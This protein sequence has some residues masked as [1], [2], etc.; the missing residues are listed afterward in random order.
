MFT[1]QAE[2][3]NESARKIDVFRTYVYNLKCFNFQTNISFNQH[4]L[5]MIDSIFLAKIYF[6]PSVYA[7]DCNCLKIFIAFFDRMKGSF[8]K[9]QNYYLRRDNTSS[10]KSTFLVQPVVMEFDYSDR[11]YYFKNTL[12]LFKV[13]RWV[14][15]GVNSIKQLIGCFSLFEVI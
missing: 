14:S 12:A 1:V 15:V 2:R 8:E 3:L 9:L 4:D 7:A 10:L 11:F 6:K 13:E 5:F